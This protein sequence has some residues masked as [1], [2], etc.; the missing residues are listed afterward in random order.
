MR[1]LS[2]KT[3]AVAG[4]GVVLVAKGPDSKRKRGGEQHRTD[5]PDSNSFTDSIRIF[6]ASRKVKEFI[7]G[8]YVSAIIG[9]STLFMLFGTVLF[10]RFAHAKVA[11]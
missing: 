1:R 9:E 6:V 10:L 3:G 8:G 2:H 11:E 7:M 5:E 4:A